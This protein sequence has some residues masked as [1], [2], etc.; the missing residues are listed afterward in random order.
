MFDEKFP[1][2]LVGFNGCCKVTPPHGREAGSCEHAC[3]VGGGR[4][5]DKVVK[6]LGCIGGGHCGGRY[7]LSVQ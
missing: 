3:G 2:T 5:E 7:C 6:V 1:P 4:G